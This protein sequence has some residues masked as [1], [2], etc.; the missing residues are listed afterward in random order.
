MSKFSSNNNSWTS[1]PQPNNNSWTWGN[2]RKHINNEKDIDSWSH[3]IIQ[4][5]TTKTSTSA[6]ETNITV[7]NITHLTKHNAL[8][9]YMAILLDHPNL[10]V[11]RQF[12]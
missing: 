6:L 9:Q 11:G 2:E 5:H 12:S 7:T 10:K 8:F 3:K 1:K 4:G